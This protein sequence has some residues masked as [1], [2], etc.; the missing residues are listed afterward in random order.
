M[1]PRNR[2]CSL[3]ACTQ[4]TMGHNDATGPIFDHNSTTTVEDVCK[5]TVCRAW[6][7]LR[8]STFRLTVYRTLRTVG[9]YARNPAV[10]I[11]LTRVHI[12]SR[13]QWSQQHQH[14]TLNEWRNMLFTDESRFSL[15]ND[16]CRTIIW[17][18]HGTQFH[19]T[20]IV[21]NHPF[22]G[23]GILKWAGIMFSGR[24]DLHIVDGCTVNAQRYRDEVLEPH[25]HLFRGAVGPHFIFM[26]TARP[27]RGHLL[28]DYLE[29]EDIQCM[30]WPAMSP[31]WTL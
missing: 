25:L 2:R 28:D 21:E 4:S 15:N 17:R 5:S 1:V 31:E 24:T 27:H 16:S 12:W 18:E 20:N 13:L 8:C 6:R 10:C 14:Q 7:S 22:G 23:G 3:D 30:D 19:P 9:L 26:D 29:R 11:P